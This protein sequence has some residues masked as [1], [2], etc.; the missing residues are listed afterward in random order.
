MSNKGKSNCKKFEE[1][2]VKPNPKILVFKYGT[3]IDKH[4]KYTR[5]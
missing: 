5:K 1:P 2:N 3:Q 4:N